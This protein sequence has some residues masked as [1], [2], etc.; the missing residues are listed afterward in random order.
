M[1]LFGRQRD[2]NFVIGV[3]REL[4]DN[5]I[6]QQVDYYKPYLQDTKSKDT[7]NLYGEAS[8]QKTY[9]QPVRL[10]CLIDYQ[11]KIP[12]ED[13]QFGIDITRAAVF[14]FLKPKLEEVVLVP[15][16]ADIIEYRGQYFEV[17][18]V[19]EGSFFMGKDRSYSKSVEKDFGRSLSIVCTCN[20]TRS[21]RLQITKGRL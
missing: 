18:D 14:N 3:N 9:H 5:I 13:D 2:I 6:E 21:T 8:A 16:L 7:A 11:E 19:G 17:N 10:T 12:G 15:E 20:L 1:A 4:L